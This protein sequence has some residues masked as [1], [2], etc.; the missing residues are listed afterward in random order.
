MINKITKEIITCLDNNCPLA[1]LTLALTLPD[2]CGKA[3]YPDLSGN[4]N[5]KARYVK[6]FDDYIGDFEKEEVKGLGL[7]RYCGE[8]I[9]S[10]RCSMLHQG[11]PNIDEKYSEKRNII[12]FELLYKQNEGCNELI[13]STVARV[14]TDSDGK[15]IA[16]D[17]QYSINVRDLCWRI[18]NL[19]EICFK[20]NKDKFDFFEY[21]IYE[22][23]FITR[24]LF[25]VKK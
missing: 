20:N 21:N 19:A 14:V 25:E 2:I 5:C 23:D 7:P 15:E 4:K 24:D 8:L 3:M 10:L 9:Y 12:R 16:V 6:W 17:N 18:C 1:A 11:N 22:M 13:G